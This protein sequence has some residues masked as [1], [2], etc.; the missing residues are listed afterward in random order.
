MYIRNRFIIKEDTNVKFKQGGISEHLNTF[1]SYGRKLA[2]NE[3][4]ASGL[5]NC[6]KIWA[7]SNEC[8]IE[9]VGFYVL[10]Y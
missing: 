7:Q 3:S 1:P 4:Y 8:R 10:V 5:V 6:S 9:I 2:K